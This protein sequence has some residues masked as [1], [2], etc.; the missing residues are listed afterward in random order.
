MLAGRNAAWC[1]GLVSLGLLLLLT[2]MLPVAPRLEERAAELA[3]PLVQTSAGVLR[4]ISDL[5]LH[6]GEVGALTRENAAL[7]LENARLEGEA[8]ALRERALASTHVAALIEA[9]GTASG[10]TLAAPVLLRDPSP[11]RQVLVVGRG[12]RDGVAVGQPALGPGPTLVGVV[13]QVEERSARV[14]LL[15]DRASAVPVFLERSRTPAA[16]TGDG[17][18]GALKLELVPVGIGS[19]EGDLVLTSALGG[20]LPAG[21]PVGRVTHAV[22]RE[23]ELFQSIEVAPLTDY[24]RVEHV[25]VLI[26]FHAGSPSM[27]PP[28]ETAR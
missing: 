22:A 8:A 12:R 25:L 3:G 13:T 18:S 4:P 28:P 5:L 11:T 10:R 6:A 16:L 24:T 27:S 20:Q 1:G 14:R 2:S 7:R 17:G 26:D 23:P 19:V 9:A 15:T 21:L